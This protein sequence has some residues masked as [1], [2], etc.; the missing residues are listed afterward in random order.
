MSGYC[1]RP[2]PQPWRDHLVFDLL[3]PEEVF[4]VNE[5]SPAIDQ[6]NQLDLPAFDRQGI[7]E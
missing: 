4:G 3:H 7:R 5:D 6:S 1:D 2:M